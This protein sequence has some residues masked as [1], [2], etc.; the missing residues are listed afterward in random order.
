MALEISKKCGDM[1]KEIPVQ[2][3]NKE[4][5]LN[6]YLAMLQIEMNNDGRNEDN[7]VMNDD[8]VFLKKEDEERGATKVLASIGTDPRPYLVTRINGKQVHALLDS[9]ATTSVIM[10]AELEDMQPSE[11]CPYSST[12]FTAGNERMKVEGRAKLTVDLEGKLTPVEAVIVDKC[13]PP[14]ILGI[15]FWQAAGY[16]IVRKHEERVAAIEKNTLDVGIELSDQE[17]SRLMGILQALDNSDGEKLRQTDVLEH[18]IELLPDARPFVIRPHRFSPALEKRMAEELDRMITL[19]V[20]EPSR[21][22]VS[23]PIVPQIKK[24]G[25]VRLCLDSRRLNKI[26]KRDQFPVQDVPATLGRLRAARM[27]I[28]LDLKS[29]FWQVPLADSKTN[30]QFASARELTAFGFP[31]RGLYQFKSMPFGLSNSSAT[32]CRLMRAVLGYDLEDHVIT[33]V[34]DILI[35]GETVEECLH[36]LEIVVERFKKA[37]LTVNWEKCKFFYSQVKFIGYIVGYGM[38]K[39]DPTKVETMKNYPQPKNH[40][41]VRRLLGLVGYYR[42][43]IADFSGI[44]APLSD[45][46]KN[47]TSRFNWADKEQEAFIKLKQAL[48]EQPVVRNPDFEVEFY[49][50]CDASNISAAAVLGQVQ[51][52]EEVVIAYYSH[53]WTGSERNWAATEKEAGCVLMAI[54]HFRMYLHGTHFTVF[55]DAKALTCLQTIKSDGSS[56]LT[57]WALEMNEHD[58]T[59]RYRPGEKNQ[60]PDALSRVAT[61][62]ETVQPEEVET[63]T[64]LAAAKRKIIEDPEAHPDYRL[65]NGKLWRFETAELEL[66]ERVFRWKEYVSPD[67]RKQIV[68]QLHQELNHVGWQKL[69]SIIRKGYFWP[70]IRQEVKEII[71]VCETCQACKRK[72]RNT[73][74]PLGLTIRANRPFQMIA[75]DHWG[76]LPRSKNG[77]KYLLVVVDSVTKYVLL[78]AS[79]DAK[80][81]GVT[82][83]LEKSVI[84]T[85]GCPQILL[86]DNGKSFMSRVMALLLNKYEIEHFTTPFHHPEANMTER[87]IQTIGTAVRCKIF[88]QNESHREW[89]GEILQIQA[90]I[91]SIPNSTTQLSP[92][93]LNFGRELMQNGRSHNL[94]YLERSR[95][96]MSQEELRNQFQNLMDQANRNIELSHLNNKR[97]YDQR[98]RPVKFEIGERVWRKNRVLSDASANFT[99]KLAVKYIPGRINA[100]VGNDIYEIQ[101]EQGGSRSRY[102]ANDLIKDQTEAD[103]DSDE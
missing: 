14:I 1:K 80:A 5:S 82:G 8:D 79:K 102:H 9:G 101:D 103:S 13:E 31:G 35:V 10:K 72:P 71:R 93:K 65:E 32:Q 34:D 11:I 18:D 33:Y 92:A 30:N 78:F 26:T 39:A 20:I 17:W 36:Y 91:N 25:E 81:P 87:Y 6:E 23:S 37:N 28:S 64:W 86:S 95:L 19:G 29:A 66:G 16:R 47:P 4:G 84:L 27:Y 83:F 68:K 98:A 76:P 94:E 59:I 49:L 57:R 89:D 54:R 53:K 38:L 51:N 52:G 67:N 70:K 2:T 90:T 75:I 61:L 44:T 15:D 100:A 42:R 97:R 77:N 50:Q 96:E 56:K 62:N 7:W 60:V 85:F 55:T 41:E 43:L 73:V 24:N 3:A 48:T 12:I 88:D 74:V 58:V 63:D 69:F 22:P 40:K 99:Q 45:L 46:L 21:S